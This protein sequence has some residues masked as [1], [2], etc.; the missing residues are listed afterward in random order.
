MDPQRPQRSDEGG[1]PTKVPVDAEEEKQRLV[2]DA[3][4]HGVDEAEAV[5]LAERLTPIEP[6][7][8]AYRAVD[9]RLATGYTLDETEEI[10]IEGGTPQP[11]R[12]RSTDRGERP[13]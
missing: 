4:E 6:L 5:D 12:S 2:R 3:A 8:D 7:P 1:G 11:P 10:V 13:S 9:R